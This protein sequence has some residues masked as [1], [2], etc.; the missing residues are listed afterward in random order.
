[1]ISNLLSAASSALLRNGLLLAVAGGTVA[2]VVVPLAASM[3]TTDNCVCTN[4]GKPTCAGVPL[5]DT[6]DCPPNADCICG[7]VLCTHDGSATP[8]GPHTYV[9]NGQTRLMVE[10]VTAGC[11]DPL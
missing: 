7:I 9:E 1:M 6:I 5:Q 10:R 4:N 2:C 8:P 11:S 3:M